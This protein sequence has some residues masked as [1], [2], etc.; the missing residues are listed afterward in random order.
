MIS[1]RLDDY[2]KRVETLLRLNATKVIG[3]D[4]LDA[5]QEGVSFDDL[6]KT[7]ISTGTN[8][9]LYGVPGSGKSWTIEH[10]YCKKG[11]H[12]ERLVFH[13]D[14]TYSDFIGQILPVV[15]RRWSSKLSIYSRTV[16]QYFERCL[17]ESNRRVYS[18]N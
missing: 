13:P 10:E 14:Y 4:S 11:T 9:L 17:S 1:D 12:V 3:L 8:V 2:Q 7:R 16:Y 18:S 15:G 5:D 6:E